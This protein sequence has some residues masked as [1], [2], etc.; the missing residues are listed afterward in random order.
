MEHHS[1][2]CRSYTTARRF[3][4]VIGNIE[5][6]ALP[7]PFT[8]PQLAGALCTFVVML[9]TQGVWA[10]FGLVNL[11]VLVL[12]PL[13][14][15]RLMRRPRIEGRTAWRFALG[16]GTYAQ[17]RLARHAKVPA[18]PVRVRA[19]VV[20]EDLYTEPSHGVESSHG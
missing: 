17:H 3:P 10:H 19:R 8:I 4:R 14:V 1:I 2:E 5:G 13:L 18:R 11:L 16:A 7:V 6:F 15:G 12:V 9:K 20:F